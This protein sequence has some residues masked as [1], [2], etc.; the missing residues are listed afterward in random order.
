M[1]ERIIE[2]FPA[3]TTETAKK[4][5]TISMNT[6]EAL[7]EKLSDMMEEEMHDAEK[8][9]ECAL[10]WKDNATL[11]GICGK[12]NFFSDDEVLYINSEEIPFRMISFG[13]T[14]VICGRQDILNT[15][16]CDL[17][18]K[19]CIRRNCTSCRTCSGIC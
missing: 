5:L 16:L 9:I 11:T 19:Y 6:G 10:K 18:F 4:L 2:S 12:E 14:T 17:V 13:Y 15:G 3:G 8:Y 7:G 1:L